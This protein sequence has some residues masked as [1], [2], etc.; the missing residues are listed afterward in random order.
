MQRGGADDQVLSRRSR[1]AGGVPGGE[2]RAIAAAS[3]RHD[4]GPASLRVG[5]ARGRLRQD[6][7][8]PASRLA[9]Q[10]LPVRSTRRPLHQQPGQAAAQSSAGPANCPI[11]SPPHDVGRSAGGPS[12]RLAHGTAGPRRSGNDVLGGP[13]RE[14]AGRASTTG[15]LDLAN[16]LV[17]VRGK[18]RRERFSPIGSF[19]IKAIERWL[20]VATLPAGEP[21]GLARRRCLSTVRT[22]A[23]DAQH[24][25][26]AG[27]TPGDDGLAIRARRPTRSATALPR[28]CS[29]AAPTSAASRSCWGTR[30]SSPRR[31]TRTSAPPASARRTRRHIR[32][33]AESPPGLSAFD[34]LLRGRLADFPASPAG[35]PS[36]HNRYDCNS[37]TLPLARPGPEA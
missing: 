13:A 30:A 9:P 5:A 2:L 19:A 1:R 4:L 16:G 22:P 24:R 11:S 28:T 35:P 21:P 3:R 33:P 31:S 6:V 17:R 26:D 36:R 29:T 12:R 32:G 8:R 18:G 20:A 7:H 23:H 37:S 14:R 34:L 10:L 27:K 25:P 15:D